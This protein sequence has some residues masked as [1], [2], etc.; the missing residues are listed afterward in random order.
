MAAI[1]EQL[2]RCVY[3]RSPQK[4]MSKTDLCLDDRASIYDP[5]L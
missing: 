1:A 5:G 4:K 2:E 3:Y